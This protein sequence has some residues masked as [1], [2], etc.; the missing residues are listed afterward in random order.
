M[1][2][3]VITIVVILILAL[4]AFGSS[5]DVM[6]NTDYS[7]FVNNLSEVGYAF[8][9]A[10]VDIQGSSMLVN[11]KKRDEQ[12]YNFIAKGGQKEKDFLI[13]SKVPDYTIIQDSAEIGMDLPNMKIESGTGKMLAA[14]YVTSK[15]G[16]V[17]VWPP[18]EYE[19][20]YYITDKDT[21][22]HKMQTNITI[23]NEDIVI[24]LDPEWGSIVD[25]VIEQ[26]EI[27]DYE[28]P[29]E[30]GHEHD[31][32]AKEATAEYFYAEATCTTSEKYYYKCLYCE[33]K[34][35][36]TYNWGDPL[37]HSFGEF[38]VISEGNCGGAG[39][40]KRVCSRCN[41]SEFVSIPKNSA[42]HIGG[43]ISE[44]RVVASC[45]TSGIE[46]IKCKTCNVVFRTNTLDKNPNNHAGNVK[47][48]TTVKPTCTT[49][50]TQ[51]EKCT[52]CNKTL[53]TETLKALG[54]S[55]GEYVSVKTANCVTK[56]INERT[57]S[58]C[59]AKETVETEKDSTN[60]AGGS[61][62]KEIIDATCTKD[63][64]T[65]TKCSLCKAKLSS[66]PIA[67]K[68]HSYTNKT[69]TDKYLKSEA[70][71]IATQVYYYKC[72][73]CD[74]SAKDS[75]TPEAF[76][77]SAGSLDKTNHVGTVQEHYTAPTATTDGRKWTTCSACGTELSSEVI[78]KFAAVAVYSADDNSL[79][80]YK[81]AD[82]IVE[83]SQ[84]RGRT[85]TALYEN[86]EN[87]TVVSQT[88]LWHGKKD[89]IKSVYVE[90]E[91]SPLVVQ[92]WFRDLRKVETMDLRK[93]DT[94]NVNSLTN[95]FFHTGYN[96]QKL[97]IHASGWNTE[98]VT[99]M[100][101]TFDL[102][103]YNSKEVFI[104][105]SG[106]NTKNVE[107]TT[108]MFNCCGNVAKN[109]EIRGLD[110][111]DTSSLTGAGD[112]FFQTGGL[113]ENWTIGDLSKKEII[114]SDGSKYV[115]W[116]TS[117][118]K[119]AFEMFRGT[120]IYSETWSIG[121]ISTWN[122]SSLESASYMFENV[123]RFS[124]NIELDLSSWDTSNI[125]N[126]TAMFKDAGYGATNLKIDISNWDTSLVTN[127]SY[128]FNGTGGISKSAIIIGLNDL[129]T[130]NVTNMSYMF[131]GSGFTTLTVETQLIGDLDS[132]GVIGSMDMEMLR[133]GILT[134]VEFDKNIVDINFD[135]EINTSDIARLNAYILNKI[136]I[137]E[138]KAPLK[139]NTS[140][141]TNMTSMFQNTK[142][143]VLDL[144]R[145]DTSSV[146]TMTN[147]FEGMKY[148]ERVNLG[149]GFRFFGTNCYLPVP[150]NEYI[151][152]ADGYWYN[153]ENGVQYT[154]TA[155]PNNT[156]ATYITSQMEV[157]LAP[158]ITW[159]DQGG[160]IINRNQI[161]SITIA[162]T[163]EVAGKTIVDQWDASTSSQGKCDNV[164]PV[165]AYVED[166]GLGKGT[167]KLTIAGN[168]T[169]KVYANPDSSY[170]FGT[171]KEGSGDAFRNM[172]SF[173]GG[174]IFDTS[175]ATTLERFLV[176]ATSLE[177]I[178]VGNWDISNVTSLFGTFG[179]CYKVKELDVG[180]WNTSK[181]TTTYAMFQNCITLTELDVATK[182]VTSNGKTYTAWDV[183]NVES[184]KGMFTSTSNEYLGKITKLEVENWDTSSATDMS[185]MFNGCASLTELDLSNW[186]VSKVTDMSWMFADCI[187]M[188]EYN[189]TGWDTSSVTH[190]N[191]LFNDNRSLVTID[192]SDFDTQNIRQFTQVFELC[193]N[194]EKI[195]GLENWD[196]TSAGTML[197]MFANSPKLKVLDLSSFDT[198]SVVNICQMFAWCYGLEKIYVSEKWDM[199]N[200]S[201][202]TFLQD[203]KPSGCNQHVFVGCTKLVGGAGTT[204]ANN[205]I[206]YIENEYAYDYIYAHIDEG[207]SN[208]G[209]LTHISMKQ[210]PM[211]AANSTWY[212]QGGTTI[213]RNQI[214]SITI[215]DT[216][217]VAGKTII[218]QW[219]A[220][221]SSTGTTDDIGPVTA[222]V[223]DDGLG[224]GTYKLI[225]AG[226][227]TGK[228]YANPDSNYAFG[229][230]KAN[231]GDT[232]INVTSFNGGE[233]FD[234][235][236]AT[237]LKM[238]FG[239]AKSIKRIDTENWNVSNA[240]DLY[241]I[242]GR[243]G[244]LETLDI[245][246]W[247]TSKVVDMAYMF[248]DCQNLKSVDVGHFNTS[249]V[250]NLS[251]MFYNCTSLTEL[252]VAKNTVTANG[253]TY[254][255]W[256]TSK[257]KDF[258]GM[259]ASESNKFAGKITKLEVENWD[260]SSAETMRSMFMGCSSLTEL[261]LSKWNVSKVT[262]VAHMFSDCINMKE[263]DFTGWD[264]SSLIECYSMFN[265][266]K[267][268]EVLD[269]S[270]FDVGKVEYFS[271]MFELCENLKEIKGLE[272]WDTG[273]VLGL[274]QMFANSKKLTEL[275][276]SSFD[277]S[278]V[279]SICQAFRGCSSLEK[280]YVSEKW[281][282]SSLVDEDF[283]ADD[284][285][286]TGNMKHAFEGCTKLV[287]GA[288]TAYATT[289]VDYSTNPRDAIYAH[290]DE[291]SSNPGYLTDIEMKSEPVLA[292]SSTWYLQGG[293]TINRNQIS[294]ITIADSYNTTGKTVV[295]QWDASQLSKG[296][297]DNIGPVTA[298]VEDDGLGN[299]TYKLTL[300]GN[301]SGKVYANPDSSYV[302]GTTYE[303]SGDA[304]INMTSFN[305]GEIFDTSKATSL[306][307]AFKHAQKLENI[308]VADWDTSNVTNLYIMFGYC[309]S[310]KSL[311]LSAWDV[312]QVTNM[313]YMFGVPNQDGYPDMQITTI[314]DVSNW[315]TSNVTTM[316]SM[317]QGCVKLSE[318]NVAN[319]DTS[320]VTDMAYMFRGCESLKQVDVSN[321][322]TSNVETTRSMFE[323][324]R[325]IENLNLKNWNTSKVVDM[326][327]M[328]SKCTSL[329]ELDLSSW[330]V[331]SVELMYF[332]FGGCSNLATLSLDN[333]NTSSV[334]DTSYMF[335]RCDSLTEI[336][337]S[338]FDTSLVFNMGKMFES[339]DKLEVIYVSDKWSIDNL[340]S[341]TF[342]R[343]VDSYC[344][345]NTNLFLNSP[346]L[347]GGAGT[348]YADNHLDYSINSG[349]YIYARIDEG[350]TNPG[351]LT[352]K[353]EGK[354]FAI[355]SE[356]D[357]SLRFYKNSD[358]VNEGETYREL[359][360]T[361][362][363]TGFETD[364]YTY[365]GGAPWYEDRTLFEKVVAVEEISP[366]STAY[367]CYDFSNA[368]EIDLRKVNTSK[369]TTMKYMFSNSGQK[370]ESVKIDISSWNTVNVTTMEYMFQRAGYNTNKFEIIGL[371]TF[372]TS[373]VKN[374]DSMFLWAGTSATEWN[375]GDLSKWNTTNVTD[376]GFL[377]TAAGSKAETWDIGDLSTKT[378][379]K[380][381]GTTY[382]A[383]N[384]S[385]V[386]DMY[387][388]FQ[389]TG[390]G[391]TGTFSLK[392]KNWTPVKLQD[393]MQMF[394]DSG[395]NAEIY[396]LDLSGWD[397]SETAADMKN[398]FSGVATNAQVINLNIKDLDISKALSIERFFADL[399]A[400]AEPF[401]LDLSGVNTGTLST[402]SMFQGVTKLYQI[403]L[404]ENV[405]LNGNG[406]YLPIPLEDNIPGADG[407]WYN[408]KTGV[409]YEPSE[410]PTN[411][412]A[413]YTAISPYAEAFA[414]Y[415]ATDNSLRFYKS[416]NVPTS[417]STYNELVA[418]NVYTGFEDIEYATD[419]SVPWY[420]NRENIKTVVVENVVSPISTDYWFYGLTNATSMD[421]TKLDTSETVTMHAMFYQA[422]YNTNNFVLTGLENW[423]TSKVQWMN[424]MFS[425]M[426]YN[427]T[428]FNL[429]LSAWDTND[430]EYMSTMFYMMGHDS[431]TFALVGLDGWNT[432]SLYATDGMFGSVG[433]S[434]TTWS[435]GDLS[436]WNVTKITDM[437]GMFSSAGYNARAW[438]IGNL[439]AWTT[440]NLT[441]ADSMFKQ[442]GYNSSEITL[443][444]SGF[445]TTNATNLSNMFDGMRK[446]SRITLGRN[447]SFKG[448]GTTSCTLPTPTSANITGADGKWYN[449]LTKVGYAPANVPTKTAATYIAVNPSSSSG[450]DY[451]TQD[452][453]SVCGTRLVG[454]VCPGCNVSN[455]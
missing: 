179:Y 61:T 299:G 13:M 286:E 203:D 111:W 96:A 57:C 289:H 53:K 15:T 269:V 323:I 236:R 97:T 108:A 65:I 413:T 432:S 329:T 303:E 45:S 7:K 164:G 93:L 234:T 207:P 163:Y 72:S 339:C 186:N 129:D 184:F 228:V 180:K 445:N 312:S 118:L 409:G 120:G 83:G 363:Y 382:T 450:G 211:L 194:L 248:Y 238:M 157:M 429:D 385:N 60:H 325:L 435:I 54:H 199:S 297:S 201:D 354:A 67:K 335:S 166:D 221:T 447:F 255:A 268:V 388:M 88:Y 319:W 340:S 241:G 291:G 310:I 390:K 80:F 165:T 222:Y 220:S 449:I 368:T 160:T 349:D 182:T 448:N 144:G 141:V 412:A 17:F 227:G 43:E 293:S 170:A 372:D 254:I 151:L 73:A 330:N 202:N 300:A 444:L 9:N 223:E 336:D 247:N 188:K 169:G 27:P 277:T 109:F 219:D 307:G 267:S 85:V 246:S 147:M 367:W 128:M 64:E 90:D 135:G 343:G 304:F 183:S 311:D 318:L 200:L 6:D 352:R 192:V 240:T 178:D 389:A 244:A 119:T 81:N 284:I 357:N 131:A 362:I 2:T 391:V 5:G 387:Q 361:K 392:V 331:S 259:F 62:E 275:N 47:T 177:S 24:E 49:T 172:T 436:K 399:G 125:K 12:I 196:T 383:W 231:S 252:D 56:G 214:S 427:T 23:G 153:A 452:Y 154:P 106:W 320:K 451:G 418:T 138:I 290:I 415:S 375:I 112:M 397:T 302:F 420:A 295:D 317:F 102:A 423:D 393:A 191:C 78:P 419:S 134:N 309:P 371:D 175:R 58:V 401:S 328:F 4:V 193:L 287:G 20:K 366:V 146:T 110:T 124:T 30:E 353:A 260:T 39:S 69:M 305:D 48:E 455:M 51:A 253:K 176:Y 8:E 59:N 386:T 140:K 76:T 276:L 209:Y 181:V 137:P 358:T 237:T 441:E 41:F 439:S 35:T 162:D 75:A 278:K 89:E 149:K 99:S 266:N 345:G 346:N 235:S 301:G 36:K 161:S 430:V 437:T 324:C 347:V 94:S 374:M 66:S 411:T 350:L 416:T 218:D 19:G 360:V 274:F 206:E 296:A 359:A 190:I 380:D 37:D 34:G 433:Y 428:N 398:M 395:Q 145:F 421:M 251:W 38:V 407:K 156:G 86:F 226:N 440:T 95:M 28:E 32:S 174:E 63:G 210:E 116:N 71:C 224:K 322:N 288:G 431:S 434:A 133:R 270:D 11:N 204:Y 91:I 281:N 332:M 171:T 230:T 425:Q 215:A 294:S 187:N 344:Q 265:D 44:M 438:N 273:S 130:E 195:I 117:K 285:F 239:Y 103:G 189:F 68:G 272:N 101:S 338:S 50:G 263:Y 113:A 417:G 250:E 406:G 18:F 152:V 327:F 414:V 122:V 121:D 155:I 84:Y 257:V 29:E 105:I 370:A 213:N 280:I 264:T 292:A 114:N 139:W 379:E 127:M 341:E 377:F 245:G 356:T 396:E 249:K 25:I 40:K 316:R 216:Y 404:G 26:D 400:N 22:D 410:I 104:D 132:D 205:H 306:E 232:F 373:S 333:W 271:Q 212:S 364:K 384:V 100:S 282:M 46:E 208:P 150:S 198:S 77:Y 42:N 52:A 369:T 55:F 376:M 197:Q 159:F 158:N 326:S 123:G 422:G 381:D 405:K 107:I 217:G 33:E 443:N 424:L 115:A 3:V 168:G 74:A 225:I 243:C 402:S 21:V 16:Q 334:I 14:K 167:Y 313:R 258:S 283:I 348:T 308:D 355:Y 79:R 351:Y 87:N 143:K 321:W 442:A 408:V 454:A 229:G 92:N 261:D 426:G 298:Y 279:T 70:T 337:L 31:F 1:I 315:N 173:N 365:W 142:L 342:K 185:S 82:T 378:V 233:I 148:L 10:S 136:D 314:G 98:N 453:C 126:M 256:D 446:L 394:T 242:F 403:T 262:S